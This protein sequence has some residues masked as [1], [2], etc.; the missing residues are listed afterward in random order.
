MS[1][2]NDSL[3]SVD[4]C[5]TKFPVNTISNKLRRSIETSQ[6]Q[7]TSIESIR[8]STFLYTNRKQACTRPRSHRIKTIELTHMANEWSVD[9]SIIE[10]D[11]LTH[12][13][14]TQISDIDENI[15]VLSTGQKS[16]EQ[17]TYRKRKFLDEFSN[18]QEKS[19]FKK[20][21]LLFT[22]KNIISDYDLIQERHNKELNT[23][24]KSIQHI[25]LSKPIM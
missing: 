3:K 16:M 15:C 24:Y 23:F 6:T 21:S 1:H 12:I 2:D 13:D 18:A 5:V 9:T 10:N 4:L 17:S 19:K 20:R 14:K 25:N 22:R 11:I 8:K 7:R